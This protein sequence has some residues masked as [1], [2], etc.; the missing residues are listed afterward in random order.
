MGK[1]EAMEIKT[2]PAGGLKKNDT[3]DPKTIW[4]MRTMKITQ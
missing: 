3:L 2:R 1:M 4:G